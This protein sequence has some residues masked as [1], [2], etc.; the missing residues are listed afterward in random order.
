L[1]EF[2]KS[3]LS[4]TFHEGFFLSLNHTAIKQRATTCPTNALVLATECSHPAFTNI[5]HLVIFA[6]VDSTLLIILKQKIPLDKASFRGSIKS[7][8]SPD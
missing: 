6:I 7:F 8:V 5:P 4:T 2:T 1:R 3:I